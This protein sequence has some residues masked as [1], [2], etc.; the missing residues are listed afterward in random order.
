LKYYLLDESHEASKGNEHLQGLMGD[1]IRLESGDNPKSLEI[2]IAKLRGHLQG[3][4]FDSL[5]RAF[6]IWIQRVL[7]QRVAKD[8]Q[9]VEFNNLEEIQSMLEETVHRWTIEWKEEGRQEGRQEGQHE[10]RELMLTKVLHK[11]LGDIPQNLQTLIKG[12]SLEDLDRW[13]DLAL[14]AKRLEDVF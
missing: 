4:N 3:P 12:A 5:R 9:P 14:D 8:D 2:A 7:I 6:H 11:R 13:F 10:E 1:I